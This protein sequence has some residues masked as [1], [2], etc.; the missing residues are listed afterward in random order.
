MNVYEFLKNQDVEQIAHQYAMRRNYYETPDMDEG[1]ICKGIQA[2]LAEL[3]D[4]K[5]VAGN[6]IIIPV[7]YAESGETAV[8]GNMYKKE[9]ITSFELAV[10]VEEIEVRIQ[11]AAKMDIADLPKLW[12]GLSLPDAY[13]YA[14][15][16]WEKTLGCDVYLPNADAGFAVAFAEDIIWEMAFNGT[17]E[18][19]QAQRRQELEDII[20]NS[21][22]A[23]ENGQF[24]SGEDVLS[25]MREKYGLQD[26]RT[27]EEKEADK[28]NMYIELLENNLSAAISIKECKNWMQSS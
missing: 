5:P 24:G 18:I 9:D 23:I 12:E 25:A 28:R 8:Y 22:Q 26:T 21:R 4:R 1:Q 16:P 17:T 3:F 10:P 2:F 13:G 20:D 27:P 15:S 14:F 6:E 7:M 19:E 11:R